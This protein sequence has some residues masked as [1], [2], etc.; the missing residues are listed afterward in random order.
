M[1]L[2]VIFWSSVL[3]REPKRLNCESPVAQEDRGAPTPWAAPEENAL[4]GPSGG[5]R[6]LSLKV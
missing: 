2:E 3:G 4:V 1:T 5:L 6:A